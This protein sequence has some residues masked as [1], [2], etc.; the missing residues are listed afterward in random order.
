M[1][2]ILTCNFHSTGPQAGGNINILI[3]LKVYIEGDHNDKSVIVP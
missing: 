1:E 2:L 3:S